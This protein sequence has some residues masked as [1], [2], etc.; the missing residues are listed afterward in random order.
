MCSRVV[1]TAVAVRFVYV[2][3]R[4][5]RQSTSVMGT[6]ARARC[7]PVG[8]RS[9]GAL[10]GHRDSVDLAGET[11]SSGHTAPPL[12]AIAISDKVCPS[13]VEVQRAAT[14]FQ[15][16]WIAAADPRHSWHVRKRG[17]NLRWPIEREH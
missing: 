2:G 17:S 6:A 16:Q 8:C 5:C 10:H 9:T 3:P 15:M 1:G 13:L 11:T 14:T 12:T 4:R 7:D